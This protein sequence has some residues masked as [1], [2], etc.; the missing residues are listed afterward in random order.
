MST[1]K[2]IAKEGR[3]ADQSTLVIV[4]LDTKM[5]AEDFAVQKRHPYHIHII[6]QSTEAEWPDWQSCKEE[7]L[8]WLRSRQKNAEKGTY[9]ELVPMAPDG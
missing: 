3:K 4:T 1:C 9:W 5:R 8:E 2:G 7:S 6:G